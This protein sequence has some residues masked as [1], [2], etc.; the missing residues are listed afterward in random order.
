[1]H[2]AVPSQHRQTSAWAIQRQIR[3][4][5]NIAPFSKWRKTS[6]PE[7]CFACKHQRCLDSET[8]LES[9]IYRK[10]GFQRRFLCVIDFLWSRYRL[11]MGGPTLQPSTQSDLDTMHIYVIERTHPECAPG[12]PRVCSR[13]ATMQRASPCTILLLCVQWGS[14]QP[15]PCAQGTFT[16]APVLTFVLPLWEVPYRVE[17]CCTNCRCV[18]RIAWVAD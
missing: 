7:M 11:V 9:R 4:T 2:N 14:F 17:P 18:L 10:K 1:M 13:R 15:P 5:S 12:N 6:R 3:C 16:K 8:R